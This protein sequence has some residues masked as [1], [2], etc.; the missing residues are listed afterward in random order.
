MNSEPHVDSLSRQPFAKKFSR[1]RSVRQAIASQQT[2]A[3][4][5]P[6]QP[7][8]P[9][10]GSIARSKSRYHKR[11][12]TASTLNSA[13]CPPLPRTSQTTSRTVH[14]HSASLA[15]LTGETQHNLIKSADPPPGHPGIIKF[16]SKTT[17]FQEAPFTTSTCSPDLT[18]PICQG[19]HALSGSR[20]TIEPPAGSP[21]NDTRQ[22]ARGILRA[23]DEGL[24]RVKAQQNA[25]REIENTKRKAPTAE[26]TG[27]W[28][29]SPNN[30]D[31]C[32]G[33]QETR[34]FSEG[35]RV[36]QE[37]TKAQPLSE[38]VPMRRAGKSHSQEL[39]AATEEGPSSVEK[40]KDGR[41][42][43][44]VL[45]ASA[46]NQPPLVS[47]KPS[48][49][50]KLGPFSPDKTSFSEATK[51]KAVDQ[52]PAFFPNA[53][54]SRPVDPVRLTFDAPISAVNSGE[55][56][57][58][59]RCDASSITL[60]VTPTTT[61]WDLLSSAS[62]CLPG[63]INEY[64]SVL[65]ES[66][67]QL[68]LERPLRK[69]E[70]IRD[71]LNSWDNDTQNSLVLVRTVES[72]ITEDALEIESAPK[73][74][75]GD[76]SINMYHSQKPGKWDKRWITLKSD[77]QIFISK[78]E[79]GAES[80]NICHLSDFDIYVPTHRQ[81]KKI[82]SPKKTCFAIKSQQKSAMFLSGANF[83][84]FFSTSDKALA[85]SWY[86]AVQEWRS[87]Y[88]VNV[89]GEGQKNPVSKPE[90]ETGRLSTSD[91]RSHPPY[92]LGSLKPPMDIRRGRTE[93]DSSSQ[94][95]SNLPLSSTKQAIYAPGPSSHGHRLPPSSFPRR[96]GQQ[97]GNSVP[98]GGH[99][100]ATSPVHSLGSSGLASA[101][102][103]KLL[104]RNPSQRQKTRC[105]V[106][107]RSS[108][109]SSNIESP[110]VLRRGASI[111]RNNSVKHI[112]KP[113]V[114]LRPQFQAP[115]QLARKGR[116]VVGQAEKQLINL[117]TDVELAREVAII[118][119]ARARGRLESGSPP[120][121]SG[122]TPALGHQSPFDALHLTASE[123]AFTGGGLLA[124]SR[125]KRTQGGIGHGH[126]LQT[127]D[128]NVLGK[129]MVQLQLG[130]QF[131]DGSLL[132]QVEVYKGDDE[133]GLI[134]DR[135]KKVEGNVSVGEGV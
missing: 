125:S 99:G 48:I 59:V 82:R 130:S 132:R 46:G 5:L 133:R 58:L 49:R 103:N 81:L 62:I 19:P 135:E 68:G 109:M 102:D 13:S 134:V 100:R 65:M 69:Y 94:A 96:L 66:F 74:Q 10:N 108:S 35:S 53:S 8:S 80:S 30:T 56:H 120:K 70:H 36:K 86:K 34:S 92:L 26:K 101:N 97:A 2:A 44:V 52:S 42:T 16:R 60:P 90:T 51:S 126:G 57:V 25:A 64:H 104:G 40:R 41:K 83:V 67:T 29:H 23:D 28:G 43:A 9:P 73:D 12:Q 131:A 119:E 93:L 122:T 54:P 79:D 37:E 110:P 47:R 4:L 33:R 88:L 127:G 27:K 98:I 61:P 95:P 115:L 123:E 91:S 15:T 24:R 55:R 112:S 76:T 121:N 89:L 6:F 105:E 118:P 3:P 87:W 31:N 106:R 85:A 39:Y 77:G 124:R 84:H 38:S 63:T 107:D 50:P 21:V 20:C 72:G 116:G 71:V 45:A 18:K 7:T 128:R 14:S 111:K 32:E 11:A 129:P 22:Q 75:P 113:L 17:T 78:R 1:Y 114:D 117:A